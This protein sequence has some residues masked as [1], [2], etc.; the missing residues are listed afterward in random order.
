MDATIGDPMRKH[1][2]FLLLFILAAATLVLSQPTDTW[3]TVGGDP[4]HTW[5]KPIN[6]SPPLIEDYS[7]DLGYKPSL[8]VARGTEIIVACGARLVCLERNKVS[9]SYDL[10]SIA[11]GLTLHEDTLYVGSRGGYIRALSLRD[12]GEV[13]STYTGE[14]KV[15]SPVILE[16]TVIVATMSGRIF[17]V[18]RTSG[19]ITW[20]LWMNSM[21]SAPPTLIDGILIIADNMGNVQALNTTNYN[22]IW[23]KNYG[24]AVTIP[25]PAKD[26]KAVIPTVTVIHYVDIYTGK[27]EWSIN[28]KQPITA[29]SISENIVVTTR[30][31]KVTMITRQGEQLWQRD[32]R[33]LTSGQVITTR[34]T[35][36][37]PLANNTILAIST[38][39]GRTQAIIETGAKTIITATQKHL[40]IITQEGKIRAYTTQKEG[41][42]LPG[43]PE[44]PSLQEI[45]GQVKNITTL[46][47][48]AIMALIIVTLT[49]ILKKRKKR[50]PPPPP[51]PP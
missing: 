27:E 30:Q 41:I 36:Y 37:T 46:I 7:V 18:N 15:L 13:W 50:L 4:A 22:V 49:V 28:L 16:D 35:I 17:L 40:Y 21:V 10:E 12:G 42:R 51:P 43:M 11:T 1:I 19:Q 29:L 32:T 26:G 6:L 2:P 38:E 25:I 14:E 9:W 3:S 39:E 34:E 48:A 31:G 45:L 33:T 44:I 20:V 47:L 24:R 5:S 23:R 8:A